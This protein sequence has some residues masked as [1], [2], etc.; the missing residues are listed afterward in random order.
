[1]SLALDGVLFGRDSPAARFEGGEGIDAVERVERHLFG[2]DA[3][4]HVDTKLG[5]ACHRA[6]RRYREA[7]GDEPIAKTERPRP[8]TDA[9]LHRRGARRVFGDDLV[10][11]AVDA[12]VREL[13]DI[14]LVQVADR[15]GRDDLVATRPLDDTRV[16]PMQLASDRRAEGSGSKLVVGERHRNVVIARGTGSLRA[17]RRWSSPGRARRRRSRRR[18]TRGS[19]PSATS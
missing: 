6:H 7:S 4:R 17:R 13:R 11:R 15:G 9:P 3:V 2:D 14:D 12:I 19:S 10:D 18:A 8:V 16:R 1:M 5:R